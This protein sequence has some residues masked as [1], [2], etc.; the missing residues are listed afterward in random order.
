MSVWIL[1]FGTSQTCVNESFYSP[2]AFKTT[3]KE[4]NIKNPIQS[5]ES[6]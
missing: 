3:S 6:S 2:D 1:S 5:T 4:E